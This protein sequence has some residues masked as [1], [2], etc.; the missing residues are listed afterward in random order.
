MLALPIT[1][2]LQSAFGVTTKEGKEQLFRKTGYSEQVALA[3]C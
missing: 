2:L 3:G 1:I